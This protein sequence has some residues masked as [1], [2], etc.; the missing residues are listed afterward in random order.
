[1]RKALAALVA[2]F[3]GLLFAISVPD[4]GVIWWL[5]ALTTGSL[6]LVATYALYSA[7]AK[8]GSK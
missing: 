5:Q 6:A 3:C 1:M 8:L 4:T 2:A 7:L